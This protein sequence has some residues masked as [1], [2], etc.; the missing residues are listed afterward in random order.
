[1]PVP[2]F[3]LAVPLLVAGAVVPTVTS[4]P[5]AAPAGTVG[6]GHEG[7]VVRGAP[8]DADGYPIVTIRK[9]G[10]LTF[11]NDSRWLHVIGP[12]EDGRIN[13]EPGAPSLGDRG[14]FLSESGQTFTTATWNTPGSYQVTCSLHPEMTVKV[15][16]TDS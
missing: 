3:L 6:M 4:G 11:V 15:T 12:G 13:S 10:T 14:A 16:V 7:F 1:M 5:T 8:N 9:G 2:R